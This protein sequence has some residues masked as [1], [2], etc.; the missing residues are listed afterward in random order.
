MRRN[1]K[2]AQIDNGKWEKRGKNLKSTGKLEM[3]GK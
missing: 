2:I 3:A 1:R